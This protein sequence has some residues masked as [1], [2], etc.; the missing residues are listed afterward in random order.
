VPLRRLKLLV[1]VL[2]A[3]FVALMAAGCET[4]INKAGRRPTE[5]A[6][7][8]KA[9][10]ISVPD[11]WPKEIPTYPT[12]ELLG[13]SITPTGKILTY[14]A[15]DPAYKIFEWYYDTLEAAKWNMKGPTLDVA[16]N[17]AIIKSELGPL[18]FLLDVRLRKTDKGEVAGSTITLTTPAPKIGGP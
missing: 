16:Q 9:E 11:A 2:V 13:T 1:V 15:K 4:Q 5:A 10:V 6:P 8:V 17:L 3:L 7:M 18:S 12:A 14:K